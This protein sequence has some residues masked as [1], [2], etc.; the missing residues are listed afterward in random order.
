MMFGIFTHALAFVVGG[1][2]TLAVYAC[3]SIS[4]DE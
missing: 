4:E 3:L 2:F 1:C